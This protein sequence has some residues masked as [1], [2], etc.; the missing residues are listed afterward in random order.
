MRKIILKQKNTSAS[1]TKQS[2]NIAFLFI[3]EK[4]YSSLGS[5]M[6]TFKT[7]Q[8][9]ITVVGLSI[10]IHNLIFGTGIWNP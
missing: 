9:G 3:N 10:I 7:K 1:S 4:T 6:S 2:L 8:A 5:I